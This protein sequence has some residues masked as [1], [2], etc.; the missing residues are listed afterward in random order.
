MGTG[1]SAKL[2][3]HKSEPQLGVGDLKNTCTPLRVV[4]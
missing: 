2:P 3:E 1:R 4:R